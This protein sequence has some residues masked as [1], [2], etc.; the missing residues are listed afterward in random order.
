MCTPSHP[1]D[2][3]YK[4]LDEYISEYPFSYIFIETLFFDIPDCF[5]NYVIQSQITEK[6]LEKFY[7][8]TEEGTFPPTFEELKRESTIEA[9]Q[10]FSSLF[11]DRLKYHQKD[12]DEY[13]LTL[14]ETITW[15]DK[16]V[17]LNDPQSIYERAFYLD[18]TQSYII[19]KS[20]H[21]NL[22]EKA[23]QMGYKPAIESFNHLLRIKVDFITAFKDSGLSPEK[24]HEVKKRLDES[25]LF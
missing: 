13:K 4:W 23:S 25:G 20:I 1:A 19:N 7:K 5:R 12:T 11:Q 6:E 16:G 8:G 14:K 15:L 22:L 9:I 2:A 10:K 18:D 21:Y 3:S 24:L 17:L